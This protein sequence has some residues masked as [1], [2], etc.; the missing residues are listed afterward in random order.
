M[1]RVAVWW[2]KK[3]KRQRNHVLQNINPGRKGGGKLIE[4]VRQGVF[5]RRSWGWKE[6]RVLFRRTL[7]SVPSTCVVLITAVRGIQ[8]SLLISVGT[9]HVVVHIHACRQNTHAH[10]IK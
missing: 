5:K 1:A 8:C 2:G 9:R 4:K 6:D 10:R 3:S 7:G